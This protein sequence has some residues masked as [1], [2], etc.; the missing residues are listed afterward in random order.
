MIRH[1]EL[2]RNMRGNRMG[3]LLLEWQT[4]SRRLR[5]PGNFPTGR[6]PTGWPVQPVEK[7][8]I[9]TDFVLVLCGSQLCLC[10]E[11]PSCACGTV[12]INGLVF[13]PDFFLQW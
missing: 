12:K 3:F 2:W 4:S 13:G 11:L 10:G 7:E 5:S 6:D 8:I 1:N 9:I